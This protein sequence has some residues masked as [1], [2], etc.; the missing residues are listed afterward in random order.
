MS[1]HLVQQFQTCV[2]W[3]SSFMACCYL[4]GSMIKCLGNIMLSRV[5]WDLDCGIFQSA[6]LANGFVGSQE[7]GNMYN[8]F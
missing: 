4:E 8:V 5:E 6:L 1:H 3:N 2:S 7:G